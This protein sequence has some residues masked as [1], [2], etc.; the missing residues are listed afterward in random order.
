MFMISNTRL[1]EFPEVRTEGKQI[2]IVYRNGEEMLWGEEESEELAVSV[3][4]ELNLELKAIEYVK[5]HVFNFINDIRNAL[6]QKD[7]AEDHLEQILVEGHFYAMKEL[8]F[9]HFTNMRER[10]FTKSKERPPQVPNSDK[11]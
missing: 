3:S 7:I 5:I 10:I 1:P 11:S 8:G 2:F 4:V 9:S 6:I